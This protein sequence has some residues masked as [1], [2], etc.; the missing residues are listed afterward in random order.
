MNYHCARTGH[1][2][3]VIRLNQSTIQDFE[4]LHRVNT[5]TRT[6]AYC[7]EHIQ[8]IDTCIR[9]HTPNVLACAF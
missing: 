9:I 1:S 4:K 6:R 2:M 7:I 8:K 5:H 3:N